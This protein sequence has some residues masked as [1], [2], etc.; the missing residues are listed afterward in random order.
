MMEGESDRRRKELIGGIRWNERRTRKKVRE[1]RKERGEE[2]RKEGEAR[3]RR[4]GEK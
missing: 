3:R 1:E 2:R 4:K